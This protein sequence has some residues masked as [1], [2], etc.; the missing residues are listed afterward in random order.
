[1]NL[2]EIF[3]SLVK[4]TELEV[5]NHMAKIGY[6]LSLRPSCHLQKREKYKAFENVAQYLLINHNTIYPILKI[7]KV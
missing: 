4:I 2:P 3:L 7:R 6:Q 5:Q 1:M